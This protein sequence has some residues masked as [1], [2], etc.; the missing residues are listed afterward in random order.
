MKLSAILFGAT[1]AAEPLDYL[2]TLTDAAHDI[3]KS[4]G[5]TPKSNKWIRVWERKFDRTTA[6]MERKFD[7]E[8][9]TFDATTAPLFT[10]FE[11]DA[12]NPCAA[13]TKVLTEL[14][15]WSDRHLAQCKGQQNHNHQ[16]NRLEKWQT[17]LNSA[18]NCTAGKFSIL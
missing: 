4:D 9:A 11:Y 5:V 16:E 6:R 15:E 3:L 8:C 14:N 1:M 13:M 12:T 18:L 7:Q 17:L 2:S 10:D